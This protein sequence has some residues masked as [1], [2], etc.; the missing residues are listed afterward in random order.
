M[1]I[2]RSLSDISSERKSVVTVGTFDGIHR[3]HQAILGQVVEKAKSS[4]HRSVVVTFD[5]HPREVVGKGPVEYLSSLEERLEKFSEF[6]IDE[7]LVIGFTYEFSRLGARDFYELLAKHVGLTDVIVGYDHMFGK[8]REGDIQGLVSIGS[9]LGFTAKRVPPIIIGEKTV[10]SSVIRKML[11]VGDITGA[12]DFLG[13][14]YTLGGTVRRGDGRGKQIG[15]PTA[16]ITP[17]EPKKLVPARGVYAVNVLLNGRRLHGMMNIG[18]RPTFKDNH[19]QVLEAHIFDFEQNI[20]NKELEIEFLKFIRSEK[21]FAS[22]DE[23]ISQLERD[24]SE[25]TNF[26]IELYNH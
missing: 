4:S 5:P 9:A 1:K 8:D 2:S 3:G 20:Y 6:G 15:Y 11:N 12:N 24:S 17:D 10:S 18:I 16:N 25:C 19:E 14:P 13:S 7:T 26:I 21:K 22:K 23:L